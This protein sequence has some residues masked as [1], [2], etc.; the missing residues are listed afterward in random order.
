MA[1]EI[2]AKMRLKNVV[3]LEYRL[4]DIGGCKGQTLLQINNYFNTC[5]QAIK[6]S[7]C[8][9]RLRIEKPSRTKSNES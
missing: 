2:E 8:G 5:K 7:N 6:D 4:A 1:I 3:E 9:R